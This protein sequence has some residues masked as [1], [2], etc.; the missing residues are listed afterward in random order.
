MET[1]DEKNNIENATKNALKRRKSRIQK[2]DKSGKSWMIFNLDY[3]RSSSLIYI[4]IF[5]LS[6]SSNT[7]FK[8][9]AINI[10]DKSKN[11]IQILNHS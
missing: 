7:I 10:F 4:Y 2:E 8:V 11:G 3:R 5:F 6:I 1:G 9:I